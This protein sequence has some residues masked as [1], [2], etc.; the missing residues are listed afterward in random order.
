MSHFKITRVLNETDIF[1]KERD[2]ICQIE[3][4][5]FANSK[6]S[7]INYFTRQMILLTILLHIKVLGTTR[8]D[9]TA[10]CLLYI[11]YCFWDVNYIS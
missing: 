10:H 8:I 5:A 6:T 1:Y 2:G 11:N 9:D 7:L 3:S 4:L